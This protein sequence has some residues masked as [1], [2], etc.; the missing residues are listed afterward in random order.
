MSRLTQI[1]VSGA[2]GSLTLP[3][4]G[5][6]TDPYIITAADGLGPPEIDVAIA[7]R[8]YQGG[9]YQGSIPKDREIVLRLSL[10]PSY[11]SSAPV[12]IADLRAAIYRLL[13]GSVPVTVSVYTNS[14]D[15]SENLI[16]PVMQ[17]VGYIYR[18]EVVPFSKDPELQLT[19]RCPSS[20]FKK[21]T[22]ESLPVTPLVQPIKYN[23]TAPTGIRTI[24]V[25]SVTTMDLVLRMQSG[26][27]P[28]ETLVI[29][30]VARTAG[31]SIIVDTTT[32]NRQVMWKK[33]PASVYTNI[34]G[35]CTVQEDRWPAL[36]PGDNIFQ[37]W[38]TGN[39]NVPVTV[40]SFIFTKQYWG[41]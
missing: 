28:I 7:S 41:V 3:V 8:V 16:A 19:I 24:F 9:I 27:G 33:P 15:V 39:V 22:S 36:H 35:M 29:P 20:Y 31:E 32:D 26:Q 18:V 4:F 40:S 14:V 17:T 38:N 1:V 23:G 25:P 6:M 30:G 13:S 2:Y 21:P 12:S 5:S 11:S 37:I 34:T 10:N